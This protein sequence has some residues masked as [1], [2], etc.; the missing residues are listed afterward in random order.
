MSV[1]VFAQVLKTDTEL[2][3][4]LGYTEYRELLLDGKIETAVLKKNQ[5][6]A[7]KLKQ[8]DPLKIGRNLLAA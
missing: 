1:F 2:V 8:L 7:E 5:F 3:Q 6:Q 4:K